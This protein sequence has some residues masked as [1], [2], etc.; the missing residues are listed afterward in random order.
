VV[1]ERHFD[2][3]SL[4]SILKL[5][6]EKGAFLSHK[7]Q[8]SKRQ[9]LSRGEKFYTHFPFLMETHTVYF[10]PFKKSEPPLR[11]PF[12]FLNVF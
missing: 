2:R 10:V 11:R 8:E 4:R 3:D 5:L 12:L 7:R 1:E 9:D 6:Q